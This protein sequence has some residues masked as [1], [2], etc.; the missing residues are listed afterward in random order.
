[1]SFKSVVNVRFSDEIRDHPAVPYQLFSALEHEGI[2][3][4]SDLLQCD[5]KKIGN[6]KNI[7]EQTLSILDTIIY[8]QRWKWD[9]YELVNGR[10]VKRKKEKKSKNKDKKKRS[11][12]MSARK[13]G[14]KAK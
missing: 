2:K 14:R 11:K 7:G 8:S 4:W 13:S 3:K 9:S 12:K 6:I 5:R 1:M 10:V